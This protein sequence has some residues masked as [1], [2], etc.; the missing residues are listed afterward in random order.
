MRQVRRRQTR[1]TSNV[2]YMKHLRIEWRST[3]NL[4]VYAHARLGIT[5]YYAV[6][7][8]TPLPRNNNYSNPLSFCL[9]SPLS[10]S[11]ESIDWFCFISISSVRSQI[12]IVRH[13]LCIVNTISL[14]LKQYPYT[15]FLAELEHYSLMFRLQSWF[16][17]A[18]CGL[19]YVQ[20]VC[21]IIN[22]T[23]LVAHLPSK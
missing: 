1:H 14:K 10:L 23:P 2:R 21:S 5:T 22:Y 8:A 16:Q 19:E 20:L 7:L 3:E 18:F 12:F 9:S 11:Y 4:C 6:T 13:R 15:G 17:W